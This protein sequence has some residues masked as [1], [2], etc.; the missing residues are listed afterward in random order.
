MHVETRICFDEDFFR[1]WVKLSRSIYAP[2]THL[3]ESLS[4]FS[5]LLEHPTDFPDQSWEA[6]S[7]YDDQKIV[8]RAMLTINKKRPDLGKVGFIEFVEDK[9]AFTQLWDVLESRARLLGITELKGPINFHF[10]N[11]YRWKTSGVSKT[12]YGEPRQPDYYIEFLES[13][14][15]KKLKNWKTFRIPFFKSKKQYGEIRES[16][17]PQE[18]L[19]IRSIDLEDFDQEMARI[20][21]LFLES[22]KEM[23]EFESISLD[24]FKKL[25]ANF[26][27]IISPWFA[28]I[29]EDSKGPVAFCVNFMDPHPALLWAQRKSRFYSPKVLRVL[30]W[31]RIK[32]SFKRLL[33][34]YVGR[35]P[36][37]SEY[38]GIQSL[39][40]KQMTIPVALTMPELLICYTAEDSPAL[41]SY[42]DDQITILST[43]GLW[44]KKL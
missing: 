35:L 38:R 14:G 21:H 23:P 44:S 10:F 39:V 34:M 30:T 29:L 28:F 32:L 20:H 31:L 33:I 41:K 11:S 13:V 8:A 36:Q 6:I 18:K 5:L 9:R 17:L 27:Y 7:V 16:K 40:A 12:F 37:A 3:Q 25:Y 24:S 1:D 4:D 19:K 22:F 15:M 2:S 43:Y 26:R 42:K